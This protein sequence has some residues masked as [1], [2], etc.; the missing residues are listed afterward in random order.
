M[1]QDLREEPGLSLMMA[2][3]FTRGRCSI[4]VCVFT[5]VIEWI[6]LSSF[7]LLLGRLDAP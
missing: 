5:C 3:S 1:I 6:C 7:F 4:I 2:D